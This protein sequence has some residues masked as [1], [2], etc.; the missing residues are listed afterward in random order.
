M[1]AVPRG[2]ICADSTGG[3]MTTTT[4]GRQRVLDAALTLFAERGYA[5]TSM[6]EL[7]GRVGM[8]AAS[9]Y[10]HYP[11]GKDDLLAGALQPFLDGLDALLALDNDDLDLDA[12]L[13]AYAT[14][15]ASHPQA[16]RLAGADLAVTRHQRIATRLGDLNQRTRD[17]LRHHRHLSEIQAAAALGSLWW[18]IIC[19]SEPVAEHDL[20]QLALTA[21]ERVAPPGDRTP[22]RDTRRAA[23]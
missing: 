17:L 1:N 5:T 21:A 2:T 14:H 12:W 20:I 10:S 8:K 7:A 15:L 9:L 23:T 11:G 19:L 22:P 3:Q 18:P 13:R 6:R 16:V 4:P